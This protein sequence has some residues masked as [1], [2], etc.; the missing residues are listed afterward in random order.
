MKATAVAPSNIAFIK[1][2]GNADPQRNIP[3]NNSISMNLSGARTRTTVAFGAAFTADSLVIDGQPATET[4]RARASRHLDHI[5]GLAQTDLRARVVS[6][7]NFP[8]GTG[9]ASSASAFAALSVAGTA[10]LDIALDERAMTELARLG[11]GSAARSIPSGY[12]ELEVGSSHTT[13]YAHTLHAPGYWDLRDIVAIVSREEK[14]IGSSAGHTAA[15]TSPHFATRLSELPARLETVRRAIRGR[16]IEAL[17]EAVEA[18]AISL[19]AVAMTSHPPIYYWAPAT[20]RLIHAVQAWRREGLPVY[21]TLDAGPN[22]HLI[23][24]AEDEADVLA[25]L[26]DIDDVLETLV[27]GPAEGA[28]LGDK[29]L[30]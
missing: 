3:S 27:S 8:M 14:S 23:C 16:N 9:I 13:A 12:V 29:H 6:E 28:Q 22:I 21:F 19:H 2:W 24:Q 26:A 7:S 30:F 18:D 17:G 25:H 1:Y 10:A 20:L 5:R 4:A 11:S 15:E